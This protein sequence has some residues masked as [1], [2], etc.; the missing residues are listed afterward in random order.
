MCR[1]FVA[2][3]SVAC[4][5][6]I[7]TM[8]A[9]LS[10]VSKP[11]SAKRLL[12]YFAFWDVVSFL[13]PYLID[14]A[15]K[16][17]A[18]NWKREAIMLILQV[19]LGIVASAT[20]ASGGVAYIGLKGNDHSRWTKICN[21]YD[22]YCRHIGSATGVSL[23]AAVLLVLLSMHSSYSLYLRI[24]DWSHHY[25]DYVSL[26]LQLILCIVYSSVL[27][28]FEFSI[29]RRVDELYAWE[30]ELLYIYG[31]YVGSMIHNCH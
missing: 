4:L 1:Y 22:K 5:Y 9:S 20:G 25:L 2:A 31:T 27:F 3:L 10:V 14:R 13:F 6:S 15:D 21:V 23:L 28:V 11:A 12:L 19:M 16:I 24:R 8:L 17:T 29:I 30:R 18:L 26:F 7:I